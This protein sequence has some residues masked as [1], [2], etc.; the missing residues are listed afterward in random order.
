[1]AKEFERRKNLYFTGRSRL[2]EDPRWDDGKQTGF[3]DFA[4]FLDLTIAARRFVGS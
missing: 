3:L 4:D 1:M 2:P